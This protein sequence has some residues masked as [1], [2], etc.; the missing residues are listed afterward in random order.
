MQNHSARSSR[1]ASP[2]RRATW[3]QPAYRTDITLDGA[4]LRIGLGF[5]ESARA[6]ES[7]ARADE[8]AEGA[9]CSGG[10]KWP[11]GPR[12]RS[13]QNE[14]NGFALSPFALVTFIW[15]SK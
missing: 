5:S 6:S 7:D 3:T 8:C 4:S 2:A 12:F 1:Y 15:G 13:V 9:I 14:L 10:A 11:A